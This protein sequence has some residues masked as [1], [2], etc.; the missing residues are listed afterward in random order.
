VN[1]AD[2]N[3]TYVEQILRIKDLR[4]NYYLPISEIK[5]IIKNFKKQSASDQAISQFHSKYFRPLDRLL[6]SEITG[7]EA[8][9]EAT[10]LGKKW[11][12]KMQ[13]WGVITPE[14]PDGEPVY[15]QDDVIIARLLVDMDNLGFGPKDG[16]DPED[17]RRIADFVRDYVT[18]GHKKYLETNLEKLNSDEF[19]EKGS[20]FTEV[21]SLF[22]YHMYRKFVREHY[23][24]IRKSIEKKENSKAAI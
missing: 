21:M 20:Q 1:V 12:E 13:E 14:Y 8:F 18:G 22:F 16:Y 11:L 6:S 2:Y 24:R 5:K 15:C 3:E 7:I 10:G 17:L 23:K 4:D 19:E 9:R